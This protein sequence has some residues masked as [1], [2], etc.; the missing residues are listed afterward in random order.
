MVADTSKFFRVGHTLNL[1]KNLAIGTQLIVCQQPLI[2]CGFSF[3]Y[4]YMSV[5]VQVL[6][7]FSDNC[8]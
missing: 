1:F 8:G 4:Q 5:V 3:Y 7:D 2:K 6:A